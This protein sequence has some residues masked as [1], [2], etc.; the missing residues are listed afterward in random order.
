MNRIGLGEA[1][2]KDNAPHRIDYMREDQRTL[3][4]VLEEQPKD[5]KI[6]SVENGARA[7]A[8]LGLWGI[9]AVNEWMAC[10]RGVDVYCAVSEPLFRLYPL[11]LLAGAVAY[12]VLIGVKLW[13]AHQARLWI[14]TASR[15]P[16]RR[17]TTCRRRHI[18]QCLPTA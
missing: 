2:Q 15:F 17:S 5:W 8:V 18:K 16:W 6:V 7:S 1:A 3:Y 13:T 11:F 4:P 10:S 14:P 9:L 12:A